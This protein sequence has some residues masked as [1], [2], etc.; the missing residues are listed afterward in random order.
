MLSQ[1]TKLDGGQERLQSRCGPHQG[2][3]VL[4]RFEAL[5]VSALQVSLPLLLCFGTRDGLQ[6]G[7]GKGILYVALCAG[8]QHLV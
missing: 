3:L 6:D 4:I 7:F 5:P 1:H 2:S 8:P